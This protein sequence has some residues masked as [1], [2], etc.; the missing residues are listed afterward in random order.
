MTVLI[1]PREV[2]VAA[3]AEELGADHIETPGGVVEDLAWSGASAFES[4]RQDVVAG[5]PTPGIVV[6]ASGQPDSQV[7]TPL[8]ETG[9]ASWLARA[10]GPLLYW[11]ATLGAAAG[12]CADGGSV[13]ALVDRPA[14]LDSAGWAP[15]SA[16]ADAVEA[17]VRSLARSEGARG[18]RIN[19]VTTCTRF[20]PTSPISSAVLAPT[21]ATSAGVASVVRMLL[22]SASEG[23]TGTVLPVD[24]G[25]SFR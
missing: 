13:V 17:L 11:T 22:S 25:R 15:E 21:G 2:E 8:T 14:T 4:W 7:P 3:L 19:V 16:V 18:V 12:R 10:E 5:P 6:V 24:S 1:G 20:L 9:T 23:L